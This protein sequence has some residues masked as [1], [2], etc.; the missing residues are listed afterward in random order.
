LLSHHNPACAKSAAR[1]VGGAHGGPDGRVGR[2]E[3]QR[4]AGDDVVGA[5]LAIDDD[6]HRPSADTARHQRA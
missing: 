4:A 2:H 6:R 1:Q 3:Q 5:H